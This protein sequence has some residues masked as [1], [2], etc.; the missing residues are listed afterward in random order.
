MSDEPSNKEPKYHLIAGPNDKGLL[1]P[2]GGEGLPIPMPVRRM[3]EGENILPGQD[4]IQLVKTEDGHY[5]ATDL[6]D[7]SDPTDHAGPA[8]VNSKKFR[9]GWDQVFGG[10]DVN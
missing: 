3:K 7:D 1:M 9:D 2:C 6:S 10:K 5:T 4:V 8:M